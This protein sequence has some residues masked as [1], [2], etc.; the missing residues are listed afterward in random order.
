MRLALRR[1][2]RRYRLSNAR[3]RD[4]GSYA[5]AAIPVGLLV[6]TILIADLAWA[7]T[8]EANIPHAGYVVVLYAVLAGC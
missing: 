2:R 8:A 7:A 4:R 6:W 1:I 3:T 5:I